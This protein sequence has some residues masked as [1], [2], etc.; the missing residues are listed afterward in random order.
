MTATET[1]T[2]PPRR[3]AWLYATALV[4]PGL[5]LLLGFL[6]AT[7]AGLRFLCARL[8]TMT[9]GAIEAEASAGSLLAGPEFAR[10]S[11][12]QEG[13]RYSLEGLRVDWAPGELLSGR[14][15]VREVLIER[16]L[17]KP[18]D[19]QTPSQAPQNLAAPLPIRI[20]AIACGSLH[21]EG[22]P[23]AELNT[24]RGRLQAGAG[25]WQFELSAQAPFGPL[26]IRAD[27][28]QAA[29]FTTT[30][31]I[32]ARGELDGR[33]WQ[34]EAKVQ[35]A[36]AQ[37]L[38]LRLDARGLGLAGRAQARVALFGEQALLG[39]EL[40]L[41]RFD[42]AALAPQLPHA[43][44][45]AK[46]DLAPLAG[47]SEVAGKLEILNAEPG[48]LDAGRIPLAQ[49]RGRLTLGEAGASLKD[50]QLALVPGGSAK[51]SV[52][53]R[54]GRLAAELQLA[55]IDAAAWDARFVRTQLAGRLSLDAQ[56]E[57]QQL[58]LDLRE[59]RFRVQASARREGDTLALEQFALLAG[60]G[61]LELTGTLGLAAA[62]VLSLRGRLTDFDPARLGQFP[63]ARIHA[64]LRADGTL[65]PLA[66]K[67]DFRLQDSQLAGKPLSG[68][69]NI[70]LERA[71][72]SAAEIALDAAGNRLRVHGAY[73]APGDRLDFAIEA[74]HLEALPGALAGKLAANGWVGGS[75]DHPAGELEAEA[76][77]L[78]LPDAW[79]LASAR[80]K[81]RLPADGAA[82]TASLEAGTFAHAERAF[83]ES[84]TAQ[85]DGTRSAHHISLNAQLSEHD[86]L[87]G[88]ADGALRDGPRWDG[89]I[90]ALVLSGSTPFAARLMEPVALK[91]GPK[92]L[93]LG[94]ARIA[95]PQASLRLLETRWDGARFTSRGELAGLGF[96]PAPLQGDLRLR[97][98]WDLRVGDTLDGELA[99]ERASGDLRMPGEGGPALGL[100]ELKLSAAAVASR[101]RAELSARGEPFG[102][103]QAQA[104]VRAEHA[105]DGWRIAP[106]AALSGSATL[107]IGR[108]D[109]LGPLIDPNTRSAG[110]LRG[111]MDLA[112]T[113]AAPRLEGR[114]EGEA[115][116]LALLDTG[117]RLSGGSLKARFSADRL[118]LDELRFSSPLQVRPREV[119]LR[120]AEFEANPGTLALSG[121]LSI[122]ELRADLSLHAERLLALQR[123]DRWVALSGT[124]AL[125]GER[126][127]GYQ[128]SG[129]FKADAGYA[130]IPDTGAP[131]LSEDVLIK[132]RG[133]AQPAP[134]RL[135]YALEADF[136]KSFYLKGRGLDT[137]LTGAVKLRAEAGGRLYATGSIATQGGSFDAYGQ[138]LRIA[139]GIVNFQG[140]LDDPGLNVLALRDGLPVEAGVEVGGTARRPKV[141]LY[142]EP[143]MPDSEKLSWVVLGH[144]QEQGGDTGLLIAA[145]G[146]LLGGQSGG[147]SHQLA[148]AL[149]VDQ[150]TLTQG[151]LSGSG[152][153]RG[154]SAVV[155][156]SSSHAPLASQIFTVGKRLGD[157]LY[158]SYEQSLAGAQNIVK[159]SYQLSRRLELIGRAGTDNALDLRYSF[160]FK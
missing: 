12:R 18:S 107:E 19:S 138:A 89:S 111:H 87:S 67:L 79:R 71:R 99:L 9:D 33:D 53:V 119:R 49:L 129:A 77:G 73:G 145:A 124:A 92:R 55:G 60:S 134:L 76:A 121:S 41:D 50:M 142:S 61:R 96:A 156:G 90:A 127:R 56:P 64:D 27:V 5:A 146:A 128:V 104:A 3:R 118:W 132:G 58:R 126:G 2:R 123:P 15:H 85:L 152:L 141:R 157:K 38:V 86:K 117:V 84:A 24:L 14:L 158:L 29:P 91:L 52:E 120:L 80:L 135:G 4:A 51:G 28:D 20:D 8:G 151:N 83:F 57:A 23:Q 66:G 114:L 25:K 160:S 11:L 81:L 10:L 21:I 155:G 6:V 47:R 148:G 22:Y 101:L 45:S 133:L 62:Q 136:G 144:G 1:A 94:A 34:A 69:G 36:L 26:D 113:M 102:N 31:E 147:I 106:A 122:P 125:A 82:F 159:L 115:L 59:P 95:G 103:L 65:S 153:G 48:R 37:Q 143:A 109:W 149:G 88:S 68:A 116:E 42:P 40:A 78:A 72:I 13:G 63:A 44:I 110:R 112:G 30:A 108:L 17:V 75:V 54:K 137:R 7:T 154:G 97:G 131:Q 32:Q 105:P 35:G 150:I 98:Q 140:A 16:V 93:E 43:A 39:A 74:P 139:R 130:E 70:A 100:A 46:A